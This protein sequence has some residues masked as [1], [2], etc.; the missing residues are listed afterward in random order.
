M[1]V[2]DPF[3]PRPSIVGGFGSSVDNDQLDEFDV[4]IE[5]GLL[6]FMHAVRKFF[7]FQK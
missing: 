6:Y 4:P 7:P 1:E 2:N 3:A 5:A